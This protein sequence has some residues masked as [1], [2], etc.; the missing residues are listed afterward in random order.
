MDSKAKGTRSG[1]ENSFD[2]TVDNFS[3][4]AEELWK[5]FQL[6]TGFSDDKIESLKIKAASKIDELKVEMDAWDEAA[7]IKWEALK[8]SAGSWWDKIKEERDRGDE[9]HKKGKSE[10][11]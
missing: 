3:A 4:K 7:K 1:K 5:Q 2:E 9:P 11:N 8:T 6:K 10:S